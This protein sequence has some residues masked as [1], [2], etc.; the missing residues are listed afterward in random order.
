MPLQFNLQS[1]RISVPYSRGVIPTSR[2][3]AR[4]VRAIRHR[5][6]I[7]V[8][9]LEVKQPFSR[10]RIQHH[11]RP[12][13]AT[14]KGHA[15]SIWAECASDTVDAAALSDS[16][17]RDCMPVGSQQ[18][19]IENRSSRRCVPKLRGFILAAGN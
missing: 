15:R 1:A 5:A 12:I 9:A 17:N 10:A 18:R 2:G 11:R 4:A 14:P 13:E 16:L 6:H 3:D 8:V 7:M 19:K